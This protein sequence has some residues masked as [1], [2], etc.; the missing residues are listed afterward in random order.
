[1]AGGDR[2]VSTR[3]RGNSRWFSRTAI[4]GPSV[5]LG[6]HRPR[7]RSVAVAPSARPPRRRISSTTS[8]AAVT[9]LGL[10]RGQRARPTTI[11]NMFNVPVGVSYGLHGL[12]MGSARYLGLHGRAPRRLLGRRRHRPAMRPA[13][14]APAISPPV[15]ATS[16]RRRLSSAT[17]EYFGLG[18]GRR[19]ATASARARH[20]ASGG[21]LRDGLG[22]RR[23][24]VPAPSRR[25]CMLG[26][27]LGG[28]G[29]RG[30]GGIGRRPSGRT[31]GLCV[32]ACRAARPPPTARPAR[33][34]GLGG[35]GAGAPLTGSTPVQRPARAPSP[36]SR[37]PTAL[38]R[39]A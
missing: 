25:L 29:R 38:P 19:S 18:R 13:A 8:T 28:L 4:F 16:R 17:V 9:R 26:A 31:G 27:G 20:V 6:L 30:G 35:L 11:I 5:R 37:Q 39:R 24:L 1:M 15:S 3:L 22:R 7:A 14:R 23:L 32:S 34:N 21:L 2:G 33:A 10:G 36:G 12:A